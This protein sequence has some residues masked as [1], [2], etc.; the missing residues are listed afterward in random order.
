VP[1][2]VFTDLPLAHVGMSEGEARRQ[3][4][5]ARVAKLSTS[6]VLRAQAIGEKQGFMNFLSLQ[7]T[8][9]FWLHYDWVG[10]GEVMAA[11]QIAML[12]GMPYSALRD[13][14]FAHPTMAEGLDF[15]LANGPPP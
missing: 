10:G 6:A 2:C 15:L 7:L 5:A 13:T 3:G 14:I 9:A 11:V 12:G 8:T 4:V 1:Y